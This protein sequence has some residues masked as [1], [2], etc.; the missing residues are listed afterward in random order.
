MQSGH[1]CESDVTRYCR[2]NAL[3]VRE[4]ESVYSII[5]RLYR[6][7]HTRSRQSHS[8][9]SHIRIVHITPARSL[10][11]FKPPLLNHPHLHNTFPL[12]PSIHTHQL[13]TQTPTRFPHTSILRK[14]PVTLH[15]PTLKVASG[16]RSRKAAD[17][18]R[19][20]A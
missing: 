8:C 15:Q 19:A 20:P 1:L 17:H 6:V 12:Q 4:T 10:S 13:F 18:L 14:E 5:H 3:V 7:Q 2:A 9:T 11:T 16:L